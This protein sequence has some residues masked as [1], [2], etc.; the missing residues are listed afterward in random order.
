MSDKKQ[1]EM[2][3]KWIAGRRAVVNTFCQWR[4]RRNERL[5]HAFT[6]S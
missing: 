4:D 1:K 5:L 2:A 6:A 3:E